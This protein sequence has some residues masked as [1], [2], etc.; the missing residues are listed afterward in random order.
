MSRN[1]EALISRH[2]TQW[3]HRVNLDDYSPALSLQEIS[4]RLLQF[5]EHRKLN[6]TISPKQFRLYLCEFVCTYYVAKKRDLPWRGPNSQLYRPRGWCARHETEWH[7]YLHY[8]HFTSEFWHCFWECTQEALWESRVPGWR[9]ALELIIPHYI[10]VQPAKID[11][12]L[13]SESEV[14]E[15]GSEEDPG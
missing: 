9:E 5:F 10:A 15:G 12:H 11:V 3:F 8:K 7:E 4:A 14:E 13:D 1:I 6:L 2:T